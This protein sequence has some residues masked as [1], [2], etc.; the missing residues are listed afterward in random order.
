MTGTLARRR[1]VLVAAAF[2]LGA[3]SSTGT[4]GEASA[5]T[6]V[7]S[8]PAVERISVTVARPE[9]R[10]LTDEITLAGTIVPDEQ[11]TLYAK[12]TG[13][14]KSISVDIGDRVTRGQLL[15]EIDVPE[16]VASGEEKRAA[17]VR[18]QAQVDQAEASVGQYEAELEFKKAQHKRLSA[19]RERD[20]DVLPQQEVDQARAAL[21]VAE[22]KLRTAQADIRVSQAAVATAEAEIETLDRLSDYAHIVA[23]MSGVVTERFVDPGALVQAAASS[24]TQA[25]PLVSLARVDRIR[26]VVD[27]PEPATPHIRRGAD[28][29]IRVEGSPGEAFEAK[30][31]RTGAVLDPATHTMRVEIDL[32]NRD[33]RLRPGMSAAVTLVLRR[34]EDALTVPLSAIQS[35]GDESAVFVIDGA[36]SRRRVVVT[37]IESPDVVEVVEGLAG[38]EQVAVSSTAP[39]SD[40]AAVEALNR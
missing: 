9:R 35:S 30:V 20:P 37:G 2:L 13:Y 12:L 6:L 33:R 19:I 17:L 7:N 18:A 32:S 15:A 22:S 1:V 26:V 16:M 38:N 8:G 14:L 21:G 25:A 23:P 3:C 29:E 34:V 27:A 40:G 10:D 11:V 36:E 5:D 31:S 24:R 28:A 39:L 4:P